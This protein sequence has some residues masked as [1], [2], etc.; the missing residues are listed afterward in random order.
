MTVRSKA[1]AFVSRVE[2]LF[3]LTADPKDDVKIVEQFWYFDL[4]NNEN[5]TVPPWLVYAGLMAMQGPRNYE[6]AKL[7][8]ERYIGNASVK[9]DA[10]RGNT[11]LMAEEKCLFEEFQGPH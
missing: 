3:L 8:Y 1:Q 5:R 11:L 7:V 10:P 9:P 4:E 6:V 2:L